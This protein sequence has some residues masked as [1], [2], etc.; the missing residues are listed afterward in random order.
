MTSRTTRITHELC[1][2]IAHAEAADA[3]NALAYAITHAAN[4]FSIISATQEERAAA[5]ERA[6]AFVAARAQQARAC[7]P[8]S[9][10]DEDLL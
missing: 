7:V 5:L 10:P 1:E 4:T 8:P 3:L 2:A 6:A 9:D